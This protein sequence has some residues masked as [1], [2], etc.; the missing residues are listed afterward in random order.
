MT[1]NAAFNSRSTNHRIALSVCTCT[2]CSLIA[3][4]LVPIAPQMQHAHTSRLGVGRN[5]QHS[6]DLGH[7]FS[8][9]VECTM[10]Y[11]FHRVAPNYNLDPRR[12][13]VLFGKSRVW[14]KWRELIFT[15]IAKIGRRCGHSSLFFFFLSV[16]AI[17]GVKFDEGL[18]SLAKLAILNS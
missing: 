10:I 9:K 1:S 16:P 6:T 17:I 12:D 11:H 18:S 15:K 3:S 13:L 7:T 14:I 5:I 2:I 4:M 8:A